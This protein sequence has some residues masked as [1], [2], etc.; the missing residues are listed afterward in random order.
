MPTRNTGEFAHSQYVW[1]KNAREQV[2]AHA[3]YAVSD[4]Y[5]QWKTSGRTRPVSRDR[6]TGSPGRTFRRTLPARPARTF[7]A[8]RATGNW[9]TRIRWPRTSPSPRPGPRPADSSGVTTTF[10]W[11][12]TLLL[13]SNRSSFRK[14]VVQQKKKCKHSTVLRWVFVSSEVYNGN[15]RRYGV[16]HGFLGSSRH[17]LEFLPGNLTE[18]HGLSWEKKM[19][20]WTFRGFPKR[21]IHFFFFSKPDGV[22]TELV[23]TRFSGW[24]QTGDAWEVEVAVLPQNDLRVPVVFFAW[25]F[26][27]SYALLG[28]FFFSTGGTRVYWTEQMHSDAT[29]EHGFRH[30]LGST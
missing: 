25:T 5:P 2:G 24:K 13:H 3:Q 26:F 19:I 29:S 17:G 23:T 7:W 14:S 1:L 21:A 18:R 10:L 30:A 11:K 22:V 9:R 4:T 16:P 20:K 6:P 8:C 28:F 15:S 27:F 12:S